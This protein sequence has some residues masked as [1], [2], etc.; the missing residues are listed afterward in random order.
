DRQQAEAAG[1]DGDAIRAEE[2]LAVEQ[3]PSLAEADQS[4]AGGGRGRIETVCEARKDRRSR[5]DV[6]RH[7]G[8]GRAFGEQAAATGGRGGQEIHSAAGAEAATARRCAVQ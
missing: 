2:L 7:D 1:G 4:A 3:R 5:G 8:A 6:G